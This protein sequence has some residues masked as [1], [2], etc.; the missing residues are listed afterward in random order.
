VHPNNTIFAFREG[1]VELDFIAY[2]NT[3]SK[4]ETA[5]IITT[6]LTMTLSYGQ[7]MEKSFL[8]P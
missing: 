5:F 4:N 3:N 2:L 8:R 1:L 6:T 7:E